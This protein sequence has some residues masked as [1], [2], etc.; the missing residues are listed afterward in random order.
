MSYET[1]NSAHVIPV[2]FKRGKK[3]IRQN[4]LVGLLPAFTKLPH[5]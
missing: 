1:K 5:K 2:D 3:K 4:L